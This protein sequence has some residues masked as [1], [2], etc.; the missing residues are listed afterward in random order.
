MSVMYDLSKYEKIELRQMQEYLLEMLSALAEYCDKE[1]LRYYLSGGTLLGGIRHKGF[2]PWDDDIDVNMPRPDIER[3]ANAVNNK[4]GKIGKYR[5]EL[6]DINGESKNCIFYRM[7]NDDVVIEN[8]TLKKDRIIPLFID[9]FPIEGLPDTMKET[10]KH[11]SKVLMYQRMRKLTSP[12]YS[13]GKKLSSLVFRL[14]G[15]VPANIMGYKYWANKVIE[16]QKKYDF[17]SSNYI[18]VMSTFVHTI[19]ER[20]LKEEYLPCIDVEFENKT[21]KG[22]KGYDTYLKQL[23]GE[24]MEM[25]PKEKQISH[26]KFIAYSR[27]SV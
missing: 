7:Y 5:L 12:Y 11:Y 14:I 9:I 21:F 23:Y 4:K 25:P 24:Y 10:K 8:I 19:E 18:G 17:D 22:P 6:P 2:I 27:K 13:D 26:H 16:T 1:G 20:V 15:W 3:L